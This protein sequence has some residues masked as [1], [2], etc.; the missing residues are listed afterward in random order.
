[1]T[2]HGEI[3]SDLKNDLVSKPIVM[4][5]IETAAK[6]NDQTLYTYLV[7][8]KLIKGLSSQSLQFFRF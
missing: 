6:A 3:L 8:K 1:M 5:H 4:K 7:V 2:R